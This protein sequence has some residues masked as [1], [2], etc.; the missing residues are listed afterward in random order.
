M[1]GFIALALAAVFAVVAIVGAM[2]R[3]RR[4][5]R[6]PFVVLNAA[7]MTCILLLV[8]LYQPPVRDLLPA[9]AKLFGGIALVAVGFVFAMRG[10]IAQ[11]APWSRR[12]V[13]D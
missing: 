1:M 11:V 3:R 9:N 7:A 2:L 10:A 13:R 4:G 5:G 12:T 6:V 8:S